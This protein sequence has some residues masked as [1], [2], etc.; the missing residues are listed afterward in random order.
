MSKL[1]GSDPNNMG[2]RNFSQLRYRFLDVSLIDAGSAIIPVDF[3]SDLAQEF[4]ELHLVQNDFVFARDCLELVNKPE[5]PDVQNTIV[6]GL[7]IAAVLAY[8]KP[9]MTGVRSIKLNSEFFASTEL[10]DAEVHK[11]LIDLRNKHFAHSV[12]EFEYSKPVGI[13]VNSPDKSSCAAG[14]GANVFQSIGV[15]K[16]IIQLSLPHISSMIEAIEVR[17]NEMRFEL[18]KSFKNKFDELHSFSMAPLRV[19]VDRLGISN[20]RK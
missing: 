7:I 13:I 18:F 11:Y 19:G 12:N 5:I 8:A 9:F 14:F 16:R 10:F 17:I 4:A 1:T 3:D 2:E 6:K 20:R 15:S